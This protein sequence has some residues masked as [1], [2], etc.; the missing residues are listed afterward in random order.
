MTVDGRPPTHGDPAGSRGHRYRS[1]V[2]DSIMKATWN[3]AVI[4]ESNT[5]VVVE[6]THYFPP[7]SVN[8]EYF[9]ESN[10]HTV[11]SWKGEASYY[12]VVVNGKTNSDAA[13]YYPTAKD[14]A[15]EIENHVAFWKGVEVVA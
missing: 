4:A 5:T 11:C 15:K 14:E 7:E 3:N 6:G 2:G 1:A 13:W 10:S 12:D 8:K 9:K